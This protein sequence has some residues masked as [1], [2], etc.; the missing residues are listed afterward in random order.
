M[1][2]SGEEPLAGLRDIHLPEAVSWWPPALGWWWVVLT[3]GLA[4]VLLGWWL[5][6]RSRLKRQR[7]WQLQGQRAALQQLE[8]LRQ[9][10]LTQP[11]TL[12]AELSVLLRRV[13]IL[14]YSDASCAALYGQEWLHFLDRTLGGAAEGSGSN[15]FSTGVGRCLVDTPYRPPGSTVVDTTALLDLAQLWLEGLPPLSKDLYDSTRESTRRH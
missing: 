5:R 7:R 10:W 8:L 11:D 12:V 3:L 2:L 1:P 9:E 13:A 6:Q 4:L 15:S 14:H